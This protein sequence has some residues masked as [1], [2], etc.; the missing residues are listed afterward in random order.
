MECDA[1]LIYNER[2][3]D[4]YYAFFNDLTL[5]HFAGYLLNLHHKWIIG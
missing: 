2:N 5:G 1:G 4:F 3:E